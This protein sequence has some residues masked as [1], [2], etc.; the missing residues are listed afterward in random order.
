MHAVGS[1]GIQTLTHLISWS[2]ENSTPRCWELN[3]YCRC[4][5]SSGIIDALGAAVHPL[6]CGREGRTGSGCGD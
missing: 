3:G 5:A 4:T 1:E 2:I 6:N